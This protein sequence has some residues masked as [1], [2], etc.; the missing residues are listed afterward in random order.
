MVDDLC[1]MCEN[2]T[3]E[4]TCSYDTIADIPGLIRKKSL[5]TFAKKRCKITLFQGL[6]FLITQILEELPN[7]YTSR[8][9]KDIE[10]I[11]TEP[12]TDH[13]AARY[14][15]ALIEYELNELLINITVGSY[16][17]AIRGMRHL[18]EWVIR[19][20]V[21]INDRSA[22]T[23]KDVDKDKS[24][25]FYTIICLMESLNIKQQLTKGKKSEYKKQIEKYFDEGKIDLET[26][27]LC[28][29]DI[30]FGITKYIDRCN[31]SFLKHIY[32]DNECKD[33]SM[34]VFAYDLLKKLFE[35]K[36]D[37]EPQKRM[38]Q[39]LY[40]KLSEYVHISPNQLGIMTENQ[41]IPVFD[42]DDFDSAFD[43]ISISLDVIFYFYILLLDTDVY[44][45]DPEWKYSWRRGIMKSFDELIIP[46]QFMRF[47]KSL[48][49]DKDDLGIF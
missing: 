40:R 15:G 21:L 41:S 7:N 25:G 47:T 19:T 28:L 6:S 34:N 12:C 44:H 45:S 39:D 2:L 14:V 49:H 26:K 46:T 35:Q 18:Y 17:S 36:Y 32:F 31:D 29:S 24:L 4:C 1:G 16:G 5:I 33:I 10:Y 23:D 9:G 3:N 48:L 43:L 20:V 13:D 27:K 30:G 22:L 11:F 37:N 38:L 42:S 8:S